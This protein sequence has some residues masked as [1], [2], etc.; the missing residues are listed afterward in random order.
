MGLQWTRHFYYSFRTYHTAKSTVKTRV[1]IKIYC[2]IFVK[3]YTSH[4][5]KL[6]SGIVDVKASSGGQVYYNG[7]PKYRKDPERRKKTRKDA[8]RPQKS[9]KTPLE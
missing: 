8:K 4:S 3:T 1:I 7:V 2:D 6:L 5:S 9:K